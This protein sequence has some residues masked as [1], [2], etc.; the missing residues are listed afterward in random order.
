MKNETIKKP[1]NMLQYHELDVLKQEEFLEIVEI[2]SFHGVSIANYQIKLITRNGK[3]R[4]LYVY[5]FFDK[6]LDNTPDCL[7]LDGKTYS[8]MDL[9]TFCTNWIMETALNAL[10][11][12]NN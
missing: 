1:M 11:A 8:E 5:P 6:W 10:D 3:K 2:I 7:T 9:H 12:D 4:Y